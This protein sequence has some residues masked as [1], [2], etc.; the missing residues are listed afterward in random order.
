MESGVRTTIIDS[1]GTKQDIFDLAKCFECI[2]AVCGMGL[3]EHPE[4]LR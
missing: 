1:D 3:M 4:G 2:D